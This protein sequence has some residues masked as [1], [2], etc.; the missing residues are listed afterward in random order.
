M[1][2]QTLILRIRI[3]EVYQL[4]V[5]EVKLLQ[6]EMVHLEMVLV[7]YAQNQEE[8]KLITD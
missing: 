7:C 1:V 2:A 6:V 3:L 4:F 5:V 8:G